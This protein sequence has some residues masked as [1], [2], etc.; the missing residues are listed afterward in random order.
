MLLA[1]FQPDIPQ[2]LGA[3]LRLG[4]CLGVKVHVI[5][6][7]GFPLS[8][9][10]IRRA[11]MDYG[12]PAEVTRHAGWSDFIAA[13][14]GRIILFTTKGATP[15]HDF[16]F[17]PDDVLLFGRESL[18]VPDEVAE[19]ADARVIIPLSPG[20]RSFNVTVSAAIG[21]SEALRQTSLFPNPVVP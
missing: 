17:R 9:K 5:E 11:A 15:L 2:N 13:D 18:G 12:E 20:R 16:R 21:L 7:C 3:A 10:A 1:L 8:D 4:A 19:A 6:P 14:L